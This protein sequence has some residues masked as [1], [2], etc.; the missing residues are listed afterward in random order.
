MY[1]GLED[2]VNKI[3]DG[4]RE[5]DGVATGAKVPKTEGKS[6]GPPRITPKCKGLPTAWGLC[7]LTEGWDVGLL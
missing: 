6:S 4:N 3:V 7:G 5:R 2:T 1:E